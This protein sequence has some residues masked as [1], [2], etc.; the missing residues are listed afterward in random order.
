M[1][2]LNLLLGSGYLGPHF[3]GLYPSIA[4]SLMQITVSVAPGWMGLL[5]NGLWLLQVLGL[6]D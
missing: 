2:Q 4:K 3:M 6:D 5:A 1:K